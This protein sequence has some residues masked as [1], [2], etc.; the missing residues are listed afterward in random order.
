M[1]KH[2]PKINKIRYNLQAAATNTTLR[3]RLW[4]TFVKLPPSSVK[5]PK[6]VGR[7]WSTVY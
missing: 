1:N 3:V 7:C 2:M 6:C 5:D 4:N